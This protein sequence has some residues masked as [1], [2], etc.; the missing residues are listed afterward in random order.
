[1]TMIVKTMQ[2]LV[3]AQPDTLWNVLMDRLENPGEYTPGVTEA[4]IVERTDEVAVREMRLHGH[5]VKEKI[6]IR[7][8]AR[9]MRH[10]LIEH[11]QFT[12]FIGVNI[13]QSARQSPVAPQVLEY[14]L[15]LQTRSWKVEGM[16]KGEDEITDDI[17]AEM[18][19]VKSKAEQLESRL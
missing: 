2:A 6:I 13:L 16:L 7:P 3:H 4:R 11:P 1:M 10:E 9:E 18:N 14:D 19:I 17:Q 15:N 12:G 5:T 8:Y